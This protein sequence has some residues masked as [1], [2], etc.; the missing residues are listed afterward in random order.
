MPDDQYL[1]IQKFSNKDSARELAEFLDEQKIAF[2]IDDTGNF[3]P[4]FSNSE[5]GKEY[6]VKVNK[7]DFERANTI[8]LQA[9][10]EQINNV[11]KD[12]YLFQFTDEELIDVVL[13]S[14]EWGKLDYL[15]ALKLL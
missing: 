8:L 5:L 11:E 13:K 9:A 1:T 12:Y 14:D 10:S 7:D 2:L 3:D 15:L 6:R 4:T